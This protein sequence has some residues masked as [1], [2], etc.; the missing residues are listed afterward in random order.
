VVVAVADLVQAAQV[1]LVEVALVALLRL[2]Q[3]ELQIQEVAVEVQIV[4][5]LFL[6]LMVVRVWLLLLIPAQQPVVLVA[7]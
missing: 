1:V 5:L 6:E 4:L 7:Q 2:V 3:Q